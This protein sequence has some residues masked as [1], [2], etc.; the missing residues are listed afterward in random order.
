MHIEDIFDFA[1][2]YI[3]AAGYNHV[4]FAVD[5]KYE[6]ISDIED[7][8]NAIN[9]TNSY[10][11]DEFELIINNQIALYQLTGKLFRLI[12]IRLDESSSQPK[13]ITLNQ[14]RNAVRLS[15]DKKDKMCT[16]GNKILILMIKETGN[17]VSDLVANIKSN[18]PNDNKNLVRAI[19]EVISIFS[20]DVDEEVKDAKSM[21]ESIIDNQSTN[22]EKSPS[23]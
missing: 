15:M 17:V 21:I 9:S 22:L 10:S 13:F 2:V 19:S 1:G 23:S 6:S 4:L 11:F 18:L 20:I 14:L 16:V 7:P 8:V 3:L 12:S 5:D